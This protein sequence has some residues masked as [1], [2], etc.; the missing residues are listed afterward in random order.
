MNTIE[1]HD[2]ALLNRTQF[3]LY[4]FEDLLN[5]LSVE[6]ITRELLPLLFLYV[7]KI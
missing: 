1:D 4:I 2:D 3:Y 7:L 5:D 6:F